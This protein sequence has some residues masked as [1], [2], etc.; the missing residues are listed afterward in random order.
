MCASDARAPRRTGG[1][2]SMR[3]GKELHEREF[4]LLAAQGRAPTFQPWP[5]LREV[6]CACSALARRA[7][8]LSW[9]EAQHARLRRARAPLRWL[10]SV[11]T[12]Q[13]HTAPAKR[14][15]RSVH[16]RVPTCQPRPPTS[17]LLAHVRK[18]NSA[19]ARALSLS[20]G[21]TAPAL[22]ARARR[23]ALVGLGPCPIKTDC[24]SETA[25]SLG[26]RPCSD[27]PAAASNEQ[28]TCACAQGK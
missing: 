27:M 16:V 13:T 7:L 1:N 24:A 8:A 15:S 4:A 11:H 12:L 17:S 21:S 3:Y 2:R 10:E 18:E 28:L 20:R 26:A 6:A 25:L 9:D 14:P 23:A 19:T 5:S 22:A